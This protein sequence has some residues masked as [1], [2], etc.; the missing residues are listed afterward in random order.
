MDKVDRSML[1]PAALNRRVIPNGID[2]DTFRPGSK[3][4][5]RGE[6]GFPQ[7]ARI[8]MSAANGIRTNAFKNPSMLLDAVERLGRRAGTKTKG[9]VLLL[10]V[11]DRNP[12]RAD[13]RNNYPGAEVRYVPFQPTAA[14][15]VRYYQA[16]DVY[17]QASRADNFPTT[18]L[19]AL[20]CGLPVIATAVGGIPEQ[21]RDGLTGYLVQD[22]DAEAM[23]ERAGNL[24]GDRD[25]RRVMGEAARADAVDRFGLRRMV[26]DYLGWYEHI[27]NTEVA[28]P[29][30]VVTSGR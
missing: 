6:L 10:A 17:L 24:L 27:L 28:V 2:L 11:G 20:A 25:Q 4:K 13:A 21:V 18:V 12:R 8:V 22:G 23:A 7:D 19:E 26:D 9:K 1:A 3:N 14:S 30:A 16:A 15:M 5:A 29:P